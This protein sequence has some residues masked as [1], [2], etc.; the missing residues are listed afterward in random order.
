MSFKGSIDD[1]PLPDIIQLV[2]M[3]G[4]TGSFVLTSGR[5]TGEIFLRD[6]KLIHA[7]V[8]KL[9][10]EDA[11]YEFSVWKSG[12]FAFY[13][14]RTT[15]QDTIEKSSTNLLM[16]A[17]RRI[18]EW[19]VLSKQIPSTQLVPVLGDQTWSTSISFS[20]QEWSVICKIDGKRSIDDI[21]DSLS[22][23]AI[24]VAKLLYGMVTTGL[25]QLREAIGQR[26]SEH[27]RQM[28]RSEL[29]IVV[30]DAYDYARFLL[31][32][33]EKTEVIEVTCR[34]ALSEIQAGR[35]ADAVL[36]MMRSVE[37]T[38]TTALGPIQAR[39]FDER[40]NQKITA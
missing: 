35:G 1:L 37:K 5:Q 26:H 39:L 11:V 32:G 9:T 20:P 29:S 7:E 22:V 23:A 13:E 18:D 15:D 2:S 10:G 4:K 6:G 17:A 31:G 25:I 19:Q 21:A 27:L 34:K 8:G 14:G 33:H 38:L 24:E 12:D 36:E 16:E 40:V 30:K 28:S 3:S